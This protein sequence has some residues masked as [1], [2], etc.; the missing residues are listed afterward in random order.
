[1]PKSV[2]DYY[3]FE[4]TDIYNMSKEFVISAKTPNVCCY[5]GLGF[6]N[7][8]DPEVKEN[9]KDEAKGD[10]KEEAKGDPKEEAKG[11]KAIKFYGLFGKNNTKKTTLCNEFEIALGITVDARKDPKHLCRNCYY[12]VKRITKSREQRVDEFSATVKKY[13]MK[14]VFCTKKRPH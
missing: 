2:F 1:M 12:R 14:Y 4:F 6:P 5:C 9:P 3:F 11:E 7:T 8:E 10:P 13:R